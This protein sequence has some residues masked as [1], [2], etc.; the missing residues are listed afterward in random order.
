MILQHINGAVK[1]TERICPP[2]HP[3]K[4]HCGIVLMPRSELSFLEP[5]NL[6]L[7]PASAT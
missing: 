2:A 6:P 3:K 7:S 5:W 4:D 1:N